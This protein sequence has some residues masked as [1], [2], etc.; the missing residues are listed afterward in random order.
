MREAIGSSLLLNIVL[1]FVGIIILFFVGILSYTKA[2][3]AKNRI[4]DVIEKYEGYT[5][6]IDVNVATAGSE[7]SSS[8]REM[9]YQTGKCPNANVN[10]TGYK[11]CVY[12]NCLGTKDALGKCQGKKY[13]KVVTYVHFYFPV[14]EKLVN[15][16]VSGET[17]MMGTKYDY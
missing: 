13:Y 2:Y 15:I 9:G 4:I 5:E 10:K 7:I 16:P 17:K 8:L 14:I 3:K 1:F 12:E 6:S 11:Y